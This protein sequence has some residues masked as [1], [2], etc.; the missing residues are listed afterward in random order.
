MKVAS[1]VLNST[2]SYKP[3]AYII[4]LFLHIYLERVDVI[5]EIENWY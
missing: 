2:H 4:Y 3:A 1:C 5:A